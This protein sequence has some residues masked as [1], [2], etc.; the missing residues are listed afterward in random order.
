MAIK[1]NFF[2][3]DDIIKMIFENDK[4]IYN[5]DEAV[6]DT[7]LKYAGNK[8]KQV[9]KDFGKGILNFAAFNFICRV[10]A[11]QLNKNWALKRATGQMVGEVYQKA[12]IVLSFFYKSKYKLV[13]LRGF[14]KYYS[15]DLALAIIFVYEG[16]KNEK[17]IAFAIRSA[18]GATPNI[19]K[20]KIELFYEKIKSKT[21][22][23]DMLSLD[24]VDKDAIADK[25][26]EVGGKFGKIPIE[27]DKIAIDFKRFSATL[28]SPTTFIRTIDK[29]KT[30][31]SP[32]A[33]T[34]AYL[35]MLI[36]TLNKI[37][38]YWN[39]PVSTGIQGDIVD[40]I[41]RNQGDILFVKPRTIKDDAAREINVQTGGT[42][43]M[44]IGFNLSKIQDS[45]TAIS[46]IMKAKIIFCILL[47]ELKNSALELRAT[48]E[49]ISKINFLKDK[50]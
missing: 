12:L 22:V 2:N 28:S 42:V 37:E 10:I 9:V 34:T 35:D 29:Y 8:S 46:N 43:T 45:T 4:K 33:E 31:N 6:L 41:Y 48:R 47:K 36:T 21:I 32:N 7:A 11:E 3:E 38:T 39:N 5:L 16:F 17:G 23:L 15:W 14:S 40:A 26:R 20:Q 24:V 1:K 25:S 49:I 18:Y 50:K 27:T 13:I 44:Q 19:M 30:R